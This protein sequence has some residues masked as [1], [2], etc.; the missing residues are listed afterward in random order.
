MLRPAFACITPDGVCDA[1]GPVECLLMW[2]ALPDPPS[3]RGRICLL[4]MSAP[5]ADAAAP[6]VLSRSQ[7]C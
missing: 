7:A 3:T 2:K 4:I 5:T 1:G 6:G